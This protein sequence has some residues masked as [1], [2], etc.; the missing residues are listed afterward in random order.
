MPAEGF[1]QSVQDRSD[2]VSATVTGDASVL[3]EA[4]QLVLRADQ[5]GACVAFALSENVGQ[6]HRAGYSPRERALNEIWLK[7]P[8]FR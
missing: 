4:Q 7:R 3:I 1:T 5:R 2:P 8:P 6:V